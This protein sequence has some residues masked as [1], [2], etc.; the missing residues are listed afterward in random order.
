MAEPS[1]EAQRGRDSHRDRVGTAEIASCRRHRHRSGSRAGARRAEHDIP[2]YQ[3]GQ[4]FRQV[5]RD[6]RAGRDGGPE[7]AGKLAASAGHRPDETPGTSG[8]LI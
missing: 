6:G 8:R 2:P 3:L 7:L 5:R 1:G 4:V